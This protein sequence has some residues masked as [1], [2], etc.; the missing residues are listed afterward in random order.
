[1]RILVTGASGFLGLALSEALAARGHAVI[2]ADLMPPQAYAQA[3]QALPVE[4]RIVDVTEREAL[5]A[6]LSNLRP[7]AVIHAA[8]ATP[9]VAREAAGNA[10]AVV[11]ANV[12]G[13]AN[14]VEACAEADTRRV[15]A[16]SSVAVYGRTLADA[17]SLS[18]DMAPRPQTLYAI[19]KSAAETLA[20]R[21]GTVHGLSVCT[22]RVG[23]LWGAWEHRTALRA[24]P[25]PAFA[26]FEAARAGCDV[27]LPKR[28]SAPLLH[29]HA[30]VEALAAL[31]R[32]DAEGVVNVGAP[33]SVDLLA[34]AQLIAAHHGVAARVDPDAA[35]IPLF[36]VDRPPAEGARLH[37]LTGYAIPPHDPSLVALHA[38]WLDAHLDGAHDRDSSAG[39]TAT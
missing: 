21:L 12:C 10:A 19:T 2:A 22:P 36:A 5:R 18:E 3:A 1:M 8:A 25:S 11:A 37:A 14:V 9:D 13:T 6:L 20:L 4:R 29:V 7:D 32:A 28:A 30:A 38:A 17:S 31:V 24:T 16:L 23:I 27:V 39:R 33:A 26:M 34:F 35:N 15:L